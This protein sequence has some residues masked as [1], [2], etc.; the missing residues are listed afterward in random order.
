MAGISNNLI[1]FLTVLLYP[2]MSVVQNLPPSNT[3]LTVEKYKCDLLKPYSKMHSCVCAKDDFE[4][5]NN[6]TSSDYAKVTL[7]TKPA[8]EACYNSSAVAR[9]VWILTS[10]EVAIRSTCPSYHQCQTRLELFT[11]SEIEVR[12]Y[13]RAEAWVDPIGDPN[14][15]DDTPRNEVEPMEDATETLRAIRH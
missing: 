4:S 6:V 7:L 10:P 8:F 9:D 3:P 13:A 11:R 15:V 2:G 14:E 5:A 1:S 12:A